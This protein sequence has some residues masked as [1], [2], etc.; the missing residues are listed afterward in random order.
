MLSKKIKLSRKR[1]VA[2]FAVLFNITWILVFSLFPEKGVIIHIF[3]AILADT[4]P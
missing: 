3:L 2:L 1:P 4:I